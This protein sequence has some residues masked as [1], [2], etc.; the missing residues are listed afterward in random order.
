MSR[1][2]RNVRPK[3]RRGRR[4]NR[5]LR[6]ELLEIRRV[7][8][9][10]PLTEFERFEDVDWTSAG[11][12][13]IEREDTQVPIELDGIAPGSTVRNAYLYWHG[14]DYAD[15][16]YDQSAISFDGNV[17]T[18]ESL[19]VGDN[20]NLTTGGTGQAF[21]ADISAY[22]SGN[23]TYQIAGLSP[24]PSDYISG[25]SLIVLYNDSDPLNDR[26]LVLYDGND[27]D[28]RIDDW[29]V[30][31]PNV[32]YL[33]TGDVTAQIHVALGQDFSSIFS[34]SDLWFSTTDAGAVERQHEFVDIAPSDAPGG[35]LDGRAVQTDLGFAGAN[36]SF[37]DV[38]DFDLAPLFPDPGTYELE[39]S[40]EPLLGQV[41]V[42]GLVLLAVDTPAVTNAPPR[43][44][45]RWRSDR[46]RREYVVGQSDRV[47]PG[48][49]RHADVRNRHGASIRDIIRQRGP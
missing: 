37:W 6:F 27:H 22:V 25:V 9:G 46:R 2:I 29:V 3:R 8:S 26:D 48:C 31:I 40:A 11:V 7:L 16:E 19:G 44:G 18:G 17:V 39:H 42:H 41:N 10:T 32:N 1:Q 24:D 33:G 35:Q 5:N 21:R 14:F 36:G 15:G 12:G 4:S 47:G 30:T 34:D 20:A 38:H 49:W 45:A 28:E 13:G 23:G 43:V